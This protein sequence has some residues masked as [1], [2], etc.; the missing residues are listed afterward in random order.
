MLRQTVSPT[1]A[2]APWI[3]GSGKR[4]THIR[5]CAMGRSRKLFHLFSHTSGTQLFRENRH[6]YIHLLVVHNPLVPLIGRLVACSART[7]ADRQTD[8]QN[9]YCNP[10]CA[11]APRVNNTNS[12]SLSCVELLRDSIAIGMTDVNSLSPQIK[13]SNLQNTMFRP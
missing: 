3:A 1:Y 9:D 4:Y 10:R 8:R 11:C 5:A 2:R 6:V 12:W 13:L 7:R